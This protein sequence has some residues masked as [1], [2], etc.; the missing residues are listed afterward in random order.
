MHD[1]LSAPI[2][3]NITSLEQLKEYQTSIDVFLTEY[4]IYIK[5]RYSQNHSMGEV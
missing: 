3:L 4:S 1:G 5:K 2:D